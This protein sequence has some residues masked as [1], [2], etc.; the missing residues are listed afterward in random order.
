M[1]MFLK[2]AY[3]LFLIWILVGTHVI[4]SKWAEK[5]ADRFA[6]IKAEIQTQRLRAFSFPQTSTPIQ[7]KN[8]LSPYDQKVF[9]R[10]LRT[11]LP[12]Y[13]KHFQKAAQEHQLPWKLLASQAYQES[14]WNSRARS[15]TGV[16]GMMMLTRRTAASLGISNRLDPVKSIYGG[17]RYLS[18]MEG[19]LPDSIRMPDR[20][21]FALAAYNVGLGHVKDA[22]LLA[23]RKKRNPNRW[24]HL[25]EV[26]P[27][28]S[29]KKHYRSLR[30]GY[31]RG[32]EPVT[33][34][35]RIRAYQVL[36]SEKASQRSFVRNIDNRARMDKTLTQ[37]NPIRF[38]TEGG[39][40]RGV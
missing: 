36:L 21:F 19:R 3:S 24:E 29:Q 18:R 34:V 14:H 9:S 25:K 16:R 20:R 22:R 1:K 6:A 35:Q 17:A 32:H 5:T 10:H 30:H 26:L 23:L 15:P 2:W 11:R 8:I 37:H 4:F 39:T 13:Q 12:R 28:L 7:V 33:Y 38:P 40:D 31:A 27:L